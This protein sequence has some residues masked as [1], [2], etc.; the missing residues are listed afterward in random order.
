MGCLNSWDNLVDE[1]FTVFDERH[2]KQC[3]QKSY[4]AHEKV[5]NKSP[6]KGNDLAIPKINHS[7]HNSNDKPFI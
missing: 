7:K 3:T 1:I 5:I 6:I 2:S 4:P